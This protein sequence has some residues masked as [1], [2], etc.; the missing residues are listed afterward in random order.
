MEGRVYDVFEGSKD[1][2]ILDIFC[3]AY[4]GAHRP[5]MTNRDMQRKLGPVI[6]RVNK[7]IREIGERVVPGKTKQT[8]R[9]VRIAKVS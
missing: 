5:S 3:A 4:P 6:Q 1:K 7:K 9:V 2:L 8:Y